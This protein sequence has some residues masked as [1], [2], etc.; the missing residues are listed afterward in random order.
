MIREH[1]EALKAA[2]DGDKAAL[3]EKKVTV[4]SETKHSGI[5]ALIRSVNSGTKLKIAVDGEGFPPGTQFTVSHPDGDSLTGTPP[6]TVEKP[7]TWTVTDSWSSFSDTVAVTDTFTCSRPL[8]TIT[9]TTNVGDGETIT[10]ANGSTKL[11]G[12]VTGGKVVFTL[13]K[14]G[15]WTLSRSGSAR[16]VNVSV[17]ERRDYTA[18]YS[19]KVTRSFTIKLTNVPSADNGKKVYLLDAGE[20]T[21]TERHITANWRSETYLDTKTLSSG[22]T[23]ITLTGVS[24]PTYYLFFLDNWDQGGEFSITHY[25]LDAVAVELPAEGPTTISADFSSGSRTTYQGGF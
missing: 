11:E 19:E 25:M 6:F 7:G 5:P 21:D 10:C 12:T 20:G 13:P 9:V 8:P 23:S 4:P 22:T 16:T 1:L 15:T 3:A 14:T 24:C 18:T 17:S 2:L